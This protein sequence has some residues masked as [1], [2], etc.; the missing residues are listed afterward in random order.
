MADQRKKPLTRGT[1]ENTFQSLPETKQDAIRLIDGPV[2]SQV[3]ET[4]V[5]DQV[6]IIPDPEQG[7]ACGGAISNYVAEDDCQETYT[8]SKRHQ[9]LGASTVDNIDTI[10]LSVSS[11]SICT[12]NTSTT[13]KI[14][15]LET[16]SFL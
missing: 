6:D 4:T 2:P 15:S 8:W 10:V 11:I 5:V 16:R 12:D 14:R 7:G 1:V 3:V 13:N 9:K